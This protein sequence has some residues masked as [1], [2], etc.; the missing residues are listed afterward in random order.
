[1][2]IDEKEIPV[3]ARVNSG[4]ESGGEEGDGCVPVRKT[5]ME[6]TEEYAR[7]LKKRIRKD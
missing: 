6:P 7:D 5:G 3:R 1:M 4:L 2:C